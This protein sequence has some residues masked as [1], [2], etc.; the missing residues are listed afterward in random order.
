METR[1]RSVVFVCVIATQ[2]PSATH[3]D[4]SHA[5]GACWRAHTP[6][7]GDINVGS[8][9]QADYLKRNTAMDDSIGGS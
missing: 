1:W 4:A 9:S 2:A 6:D 3:I 7:T 8:C 5:R